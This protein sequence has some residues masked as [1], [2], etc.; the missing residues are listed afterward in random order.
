MVT[1]PGVGV[2]GRTR[3][4]LGRG[5]VHTFVVEHRVGDDVGTGRS[6]GVG[7]RVGEVNIGL[8]GVGVRVGSAPL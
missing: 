2:R 8:G 3:F 5:R 7:Q 1:L 4:G 6:S